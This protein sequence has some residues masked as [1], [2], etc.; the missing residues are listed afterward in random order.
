MN[1][2]LEIKGENLEEEIVLMKFMKQNSLQVINLTKNALKL[3]HLVSLKKQ[4][5]A[6][7]LKF[8]RD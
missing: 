3:Y 7:F 5:K 6:T 8:P 1:S 4:L 2:D